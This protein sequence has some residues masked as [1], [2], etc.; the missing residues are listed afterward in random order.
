MINPWALFSFFLFFILILIFLCE[1]SYK[2]NLLSPQIFRVIIHFL[3]GI[4]VSLSPFIFE[5]FFQP[6]FLALLFF[7]INLLSYKNNQLKSFHDV[8]RNSLG[9]IFFPISFIILAIPFWE[10][11]YFI[12]SSFMI[13]AISDPL[14]SIVGNYYKKAHFYKISKEIKSIE[15]SLIMFLS[16]STILILLSNHIFNGFNI[17][18]SIITIFLCTK[19]W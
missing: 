12:T 9:T 13:L 10:Y 2:K 7:L 11:K 18:H 17:I 15:G 16:T 1:V 14:A 3:V 4:G 5:S 19:I 8:K 6:I